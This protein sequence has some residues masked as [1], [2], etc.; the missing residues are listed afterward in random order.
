MPK[1]YSIKIDGLEIPVDEEVYNAYKRA[2]WREEYH[3]RRRRKTEYSLDVLGEA[4]Y[5]PPDTG[6]LVEDIV[7]DNALLEALFASLHTLTDDERSIINAIF[8]EGRTLRE[9]AK[10]YGVSQVTIHKR[11]KKIIEKLKKTFE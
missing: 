7:C 11:E 9:I 4:G 10:E 2:E 3:D 5:E 8:Y 6:E 1:K